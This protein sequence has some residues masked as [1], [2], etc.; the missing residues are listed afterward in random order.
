[1]ISR[2]API[3]I[4]ISSMLV[5]SGPNSIASEP[6]SLEALFGKSIP[7]NA[8]TATALSYHDIAINQSAARNKEALVLLSKYKIA[9]EAFYARSDRLNSPYNQ[10]LCAEDEPLKAR[11]T[12]A[13]KLCRVN[14]RLAALGLELFVLDAYRPVSCQRKLWNYFILEARRRL[15]DR[16]A[17][18][19]IEYAGKFCS[20]P[21]KYE[22]DNYKSWPTHL[23]GGAI[24]LT[25]RRKNGELLFMGGIFDDAS[26]QSKTAYFETPAEKKL[27]DSSDSASVNEARRN[28]RLLYWLMTEEGF[29]NY[30]Y[31]WWHFDFGNQMW[32]Q[33]SLDKKG[34][35][36]FYGAI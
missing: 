8:K 17:S 1:M 2:C 26:E 3:L 34:K 6:D 12:I 28:R 27:A 21:T 23:S 14:K 10:C 9:G 20:D 11:K 5:F 31:E 15:G 4:A 33:N 19:L 30:P 13:E 18:E 35:E 25:I 16:P 24:D 22:K 32:I 36:A 29:A 7:E